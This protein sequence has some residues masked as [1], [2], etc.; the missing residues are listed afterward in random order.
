M[1]DA[2]RW[3]VTSFLHAELR[4]SDPALDALAPEALPAELAAELDYHS[5]LTPLTR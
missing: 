5:G 4:G 1:R 2:R 3:L